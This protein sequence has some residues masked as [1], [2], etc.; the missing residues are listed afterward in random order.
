MT[1][2]MTTPHRTSPFAWHCT[3]STLT[4]TS[5]ESAHHERAQSCF[6]VY[7]SSTHWLKFKPCPHLIYISLTRLTLLYTSQLSSCPFLSPFFH[8]SDEQQ[9]EL[10]QRIMENLRYSATN[11]GED[12]YDVPHLPTDHPDPPSGHDSVALWREHFSSV[13]AHSEESF[14][15]TFFAEVMGQFSQLRSSHEVGPFDG[16]FSASEHS[17]GLRGFCS[18]S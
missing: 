2:E 8:L 5:T 11:G 18:G 14:D 10:N 16:P 6:L 13:G 15:E 9:P 3:L 17:G 4:S 7:T 12:T 1:T